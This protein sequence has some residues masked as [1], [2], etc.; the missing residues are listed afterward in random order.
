VAA[1][2]GAPPR[3]LKELL[4]EHARRIVAQALE[5]NRG[6]RTRAARELGL[7]RQALAVKLAKF[8]KT[9]PG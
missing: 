7:S 1:L 4:E 9:E 6:N 8:A 2:D 5:R 3:K